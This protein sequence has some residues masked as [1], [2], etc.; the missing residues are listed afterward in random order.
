MLPAPKLQVF[1]A[2]TPEEVNSLLDV[3]FFSRDVR[4]IGLDT[5]T[6]VFMTGKGPPRPV[7]IIQLAS[8]T[9][10]VVI[11]QIFRIWL[12]YNI[13][14]ERL[15]AILSD[16]TILKCG[17]AISGDVERLQI[18]YSLR[19][20]GIVDLDALAASR[21]LGIHPSLGSLANHFYGPSD[22]VIK[23]HSVEN[24]R[25]VLQV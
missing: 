9:G 6:R 21:A 24:R 5:E 8:M 20:R 19:V 10:T 14:P 4:M 7:S 18:L 17:V 2:A 3:H 25:L 23:G 22:P 15:A 16:Q 12:Q 1:V 11:V 13:I